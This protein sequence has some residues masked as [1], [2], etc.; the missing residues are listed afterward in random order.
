MSYVIGT[1]SEFF[2]V[3]PTFDKVKRIPFPISTSAITGRT[4]TGGNIGKRQYIIGGH[5]ANVM[6]DEEYRCYKLGIPKPLLP[7]TVS[8]GGGAIPQIGYLRFFDEVTEERSPLSSGTAFTGDVNRAWSNL[9]TIVPGDSLLIEGTSDIA[10]GAVTG[11]LTNF[12]DLRPGDRVAITGATNHW[13]RI[14]KI[15]SDELM[16]IDDLSMAGVGVALEA[17]VVPRV[18]HVELWLSANGALPRFV[19]RVRIGT[20]TVSE[21][22]AILALGEAETEAYTAMPF[23]AL[24]VLYNQRLAVAGVAG[25][26]DTIYLSIPGFPE[27]H[28]GLKFITDYREPIVGMEL[29]RKYILILCPESAYILQG[30]ADED[31][32]LDPVEADVG[33][34]GPSCRVNGVVYHASRDGIM[35]FNGA[36]HQALPTRKTEWAK[37]CV[38]RQAPMEN[39]FFAVNPHDETIQYYPN[40]WFED[41]LEKRPTVWVGSYGSVAATGTGEIAPPEWFSDTATMGGEL[42]TSARYMVPQ[43]ARSGKFFRGTMVGKV[44]SE[45]EL[46]GIPLEGIVARIVLRHEMLNDP[47]GKI[48]EAKTL[49]QIWSYIVAEFSP[50]TVGVWAGDEYAYPLDLQDGLGGVQGS[51]FRSDNIPAGQQETPL[52]PGITGIYADKTVNVHPEWEINAR[53][54][55]L[56]YTMPNP[57]DV[58]FL[59]YGG[60]VQMTGLATRY[61]KWVRG[62]V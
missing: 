17:K 53:G 54:W 6:I 40:P 29:H 41:D 42:V 13:A 25:H 2:A 32:V 7:P 46:G 51:A 49:S 12:T 47:G 9:P 4:A 56:E 50:Y 61:V 19:L 45:N 36:F 60:L 1:Q 31:F 59:G 58:V 11:T 37:A 28:T 8:A 14:R 33:G 48:D 55:T 21:S 22:T 24:S 26:E 57:I 16:E 34:F 15:F 43:G 3:A 52:S 23:G 30:V 44:F 18:S 10:A 39:G 5:T 35:A 27:R 38:D 62:G 20:T